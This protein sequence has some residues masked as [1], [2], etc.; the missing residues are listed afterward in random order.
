MNGT[1]CPQIKFGF[2]LFYKAVQLVQIDICKDWAD[3]T[4]LRRTAVCIVIHP[5]LQI[6]GF[7][8]LPNQPEKAF[9]LDALCKNVNHYIMV[10]IV[11]EAFDV[12][13]YK[14]F[15]TCKVHLY[16]TQRRMT[17]MIWTKA[18]RRFRKAALIDCFQQEP[19]TFLYELVIE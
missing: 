16:L 3:D 5:V 7:Q 8:E 2:Q 18:V 6:P 9:I 12:S 13:L 1:L 19:H 15:D 4:A 14:P 17:A 10:N 11:E